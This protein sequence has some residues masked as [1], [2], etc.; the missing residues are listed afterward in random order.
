[1]VKVVEEQ[2]GSP[3]VTRRSDALRQVEGTDVEQTKGFSDRRRDERGVAHGGERNEDH[4]SGAFEHDCPRNLLRKTGLPGSAGPRQRNQAKS[5]NR[6]PLTQNLDVVVA[7][8]QGRQCQRQ[9]PAT[10]VIEYCG[11]SGGPPAC[12][13]RVARCVAE[14]QR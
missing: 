14:V 9:R 4:T 7:A 13:E 11:M 3:A 1:M 12:E 2:Q 5:R 10:A 6:E 8:E